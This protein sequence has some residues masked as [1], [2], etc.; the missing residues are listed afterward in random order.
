MQL[1]LK[2]KGTFVAPAKLALHDEI[3]TNV[4]GALGNFFKS[5]V[6]KRLKQ[7]RLRSLQPFSFFP[8]ERL[9]C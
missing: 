2:R 5:L 8:S 3:K 4:Q 1:R 7:L 6:W 9:I